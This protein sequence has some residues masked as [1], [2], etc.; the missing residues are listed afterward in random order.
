MIGIVI[1][2]FRS[3]DVIEACLDSLPFDTEPGLRVVLC[4]NASDDD[5][6]G[7]IRTWAGT[8]GRNLE[9]HYVGSP[10]MRADTGPLTLLH[11]GGNLGFAGG[12]NIGLIHLL[13]DPDIDLFWILNPDCEVTPGAAAAYRE[14]A[15]KAAPFAL[16]GGR[17]CYREAPGLIQSDGGRVYRWSGI[18]SNINQ[19]LMPDAAVFPPE[20]SLDFISGANMVASR[21]FI[22]RTGPM[23]EDYFLYYEEIDWASRRGDLPLLFC[24]EATVYHVGGTTIGTGSANR[25]PSPFAN[26]FNYRNRMRYMWRF[27]RS[28]LP[29]AWALSMLRVGKLAAIGAWDEAWAAFA[30]LHG[31]PPPAG[32]RYVIAP[33]DHDRAFKLKDRTR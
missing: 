29:T 12:V 26:F 19:N 7:I 18:C 16:M 2:T 4:D 1:L 6:V 25:R 14:R 23:V 15:A 21:L 3:S 17:I 27:H 31:L 9:E 13:R 28:R 24:P 22:E 5:T 20:E 32:V 10:K 33:V 11:T 8:T 30:G